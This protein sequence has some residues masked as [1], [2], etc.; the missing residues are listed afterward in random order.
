MQDPKNLAVSGRAIELAL[1]VYRLTRQFPADERFGLTAQMRR[2]AVS[3]GSNIAEGC[4]RWGS[5]E[6]LHFLQVSYS[7]AAELAF[8]LSIA[9]QLDFGNAADRQDAAVLV[10]Q[11]QR[12]LNRLMVAKRATLSGAP[13]RRTS[14]HRTSRES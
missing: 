2:A 6:F 3:V 5:R 4:G 10:D 9:T 1:A 11:V 7:S 14:P 12:M 8:Q 13:S